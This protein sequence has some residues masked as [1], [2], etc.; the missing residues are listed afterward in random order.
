MVFQTFNESQTALVFGLRPR[1]C[2]SRRV[3]GDERLR[4][5]LACEMFRLDVGNIV[6]EDVARVRG[7]GEMLRWLFES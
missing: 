7:D 6:E 3:K 2:W 5:Q 1:S 4:A